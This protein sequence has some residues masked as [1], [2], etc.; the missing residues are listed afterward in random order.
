MKS[1]DRDVMLSFSC[2]KC[3]RKNIIKT[4][5]NDYD[6]SRGVFSFYFDWGEKVCECG[7]KIA[8]Y[9]DENTPANY[10]IVN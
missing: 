7:A 8:V 5:L 1:I 2:P 6:I 4:L 10:V 9:T 3:G